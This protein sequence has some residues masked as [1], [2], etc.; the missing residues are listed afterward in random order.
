MKILHVIWAFASLGLAVLV[1]EVMRPQID[2]TRDHAELSMGTGNLVLEHTG[3]RLDLPLVTLRPIIR[4]LAFPFGKVV[5]I[6][7]V[8]LRS[9]SEGDD[10]DV[11]VFFDLGGDAP[12]GVDAR[13]PGLLVMRT[14]SVLPTAFGGEPTSRV[15]LSPGGGHGEVQSGTLTLLEALPL[16]GEAGETTLRV[17]GQLSITVATAGVKDQ[18]QGK[19]KGRFAW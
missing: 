14:F 4:D 2:R 16:G 15:R 3:G 8:A 5:A 19:F 18:V 13:D 11:E 9:A 17:Q 7:E 1:N 10:P 12:F 6:R